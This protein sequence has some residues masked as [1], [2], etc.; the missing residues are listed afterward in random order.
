MTKQ[1]CIL[2]CD[3]LELNCYIIENYDTALRI[4]EAELEDGFYDLDDL[5]IYELDELETAQ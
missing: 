2:T 5:M 3:G 4:I 1:W